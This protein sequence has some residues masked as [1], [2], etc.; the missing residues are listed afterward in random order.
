MEMAAT[1]ANR[2]LIPWRAKFRNNQECLRHLVAS[3][4]SYYVTP[5]ERKHRSRSLSSL[6]ERIVYMAFA[7][8]IIVPQNLLNHWKSEIAKHVEYDY[9]NVLSLDTNDSVRIVSVQELQS[10]DIILMSRPRFEKEM[11]TCE[12]VDGSYGTK[13]QRGGC[14]CDLDGQCDCSAT[15][16][17]SPLGNVHFLRVIMDE[18]H[19]FS[20][21]G[22][23]N[24]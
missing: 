6:Q 17:E 18:G 14:A 3:A 7:T 8:L 19:E 11:S 22:M 24:P 12:S 10:Y 21:S 2:S 5:L 13:R 23:D 20:S 16:Y 4:P 15:K 9:L 1:A